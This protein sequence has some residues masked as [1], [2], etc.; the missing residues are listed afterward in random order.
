MKN[1]KVQGPIDLSGADGLTE[2]VP[3][4][5]L[6][7]EIRFRLRLNQRQMVELYNRS[8]PT[9]LTTTTV[10]WNCWERGKSRIYGD[11]VVKM[12]SLLGNMPTVQE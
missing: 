10:L 5:R 8:E 4:E 12:L 11:H 6:L 1:E 9:A 2:Y 7:R 3:P